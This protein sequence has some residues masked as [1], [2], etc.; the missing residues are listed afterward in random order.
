MAVSKKDIPEI[1]A[2]MSDFW[3]IVKQF[4]VTEESDEYWEKMLQ[5]CS[6]CCNKYENNEF[7]ADTLMGFMNHQD[8]KHRASTVISSL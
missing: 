8:H 3:T 4:W 6:D 5:T 7:V 2:F 1:A